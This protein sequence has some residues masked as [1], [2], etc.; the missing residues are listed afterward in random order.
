M[1]DDNEDIYLIDF[2][3]LSQKVRKYEEC[4]YSWNFSLGYDIIT[5]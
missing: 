5:K 1:F 4:V 3:S 2:D